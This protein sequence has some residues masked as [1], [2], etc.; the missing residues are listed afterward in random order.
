MP[1]SESPPIFPKGKAPNAEPQSL[2]G[3]MGN[4]EWNELLSEVDGLIQEMDDLPYP[5]VKERIFELLSGIDTIHR[6]ALRRLV[7]LFKKGVLEQVVTDP[8]IHT[9]MELYDMLPPADKVDKA[10]EKL[11]SR[12]NW[13]TG[14]AKDKTAQ[15][16]KLPVKP[17]FARWIPL[18]RKADEFENDTATEFMV[19]DRTIMICR[20]KDK[21]YAIA[22]A[23]AQDDS[24]MA[25][26]QLVKFT[27]TCPN[28]AGCYYDIR[29]GAHIG[30]KNLIECYT[31]K[32]EDDGRLMVGLDMAFRPDLPAF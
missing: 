17:G 4:D 3:F 19:D 22:S 16:A 29:Q 30:H 20:L 31:I 15:P 10:V 24:S 21:F 14:P 1:E 7:R 2:V 28:H 26:A 27:L 9:L 12:L 32:Q 25:G 6:E 23:C 13:T 11:D 8:A 5:Q 18:P